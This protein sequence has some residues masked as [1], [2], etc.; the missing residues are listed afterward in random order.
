MPIFQSLEKD[1][2]ARSH[3]L[4]HL[5][6]EVAQFAGFTD[7]E[8]LV[9]DMQSNLGSLHSVMEDAHHCLQSRLRSLQV[10]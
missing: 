3:Q 10:H 2:K 9:T 1:L 4:E 7:V 5:L 8:P 6:R